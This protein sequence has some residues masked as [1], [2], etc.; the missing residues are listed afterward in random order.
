LFAHHVDQFDAAEHDLGTCYRLEAEHGSDAALDAS[1]ILFDPIIEVL[2]P[3]DPDRLLG[4]SRWIAQAVFSIASPDR[5][6]IGLTAIDGDAVRAS[7]AGKR[8][9]RFLTSA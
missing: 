1:M 9:A 5:L 2:A 4:L 6:V 3:T 8:R 7:M